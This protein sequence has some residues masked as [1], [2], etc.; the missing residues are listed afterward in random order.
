[1]AEVF[2][3][4]LNAGIQPPTSPSDA[5]AMKLQNFYRGYHTHRLLVDSTVVAEELWWKALDFALLNHST[6]S[7]FD[8][9]KPESAAS[10]WNSISLNTS[11][12]GK[13]KFSLSLDWKAH[14][15]AFQH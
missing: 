13:V 4:T 8:F 9:E 3:Y 2:F 12:L 6:I 1:M 14:K 5:A 7:F 10:H 15:L 11:K